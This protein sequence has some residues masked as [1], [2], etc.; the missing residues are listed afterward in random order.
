MKDRRYIRN[1]LEKMPNELNLK[2]FYENAERF[3][4]SIN[5][6]KS[7]KNRENPIKLAE[8]GIQARRHLEGCINF[9]NS[10]LKPEVNQYTGEF[11]KEYKE[12]AENLGRWLSGLDTIEEQ[13]GTRIAAGKSLGGSFIKKEAILVG[14]LASLESGFDNAVCQSFYNARFLFLQ[15]YKIEKDGMIVE[16]EKNR[17]LFGLFLFKEL[18]K[19]MEVFGAFTRKGEYNQRVV[20]M[21][22]KNTRTRMYPRQ[23]I[24]QEDGESTEQELSII[25]PFSDT[26]EDE[27]TEI[28][29]QPQSI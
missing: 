14:F 12:Y 9:I 6:S 5:L 24:S 8:L 23:E 18:Y 2:I 15:D 20:Q 1:L 17:D 21:F 26:G 19:S 16:I 11:H 29:Q 22:P 10:L 27:N 3:I 25:D 28:Y 13:M 7:K 4:A